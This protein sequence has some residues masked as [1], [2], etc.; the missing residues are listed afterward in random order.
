M[1]INRTDFIQPIQSISIPA[2]AFLYFDEGDLMT[3]LHFPSAVSEEQDLYGRKFELKLIED[4]F[5]ENQR[6]PVLVIG[7]RR[8]GKTSLMNVVIRRLKAPGAGGDGS[9]YAILPVEPRGITTF[10][11]FARAI[12]LRMSAHLRGAMPQDARVTP[13]IDSNERF[14]IEFSELLRYSGQETFLVCIDEFDEIVRQ[15][16][17]PEWE[18]IRGLINTLVERANLPVTFFFTMTSVPE[19]MK[20]EAP[21]TL[22]SMAQV[23]ELRPFYLE[24]SNALVMD[25]SGSRLGWEQ[26]CLRQLFRLC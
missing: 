7:E 4:T 23:L 11:A 13:E 12:L 25:V 9:G 10:N 16:R 18:R 6:V 1:I 5:F 2:I 14:E 17:G 20:D 21:S 3:G 19:A 8:T 15:T 24:E 22:V 26:E